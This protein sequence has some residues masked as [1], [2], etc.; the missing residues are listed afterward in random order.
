MSDIIS[1]FLALNF[2]H[3][4]FSIHSA[5]YPYLVMSVASWVGAI[6]SKLCEINCWLVWCK[7]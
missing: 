4:T 7:K 5:K 1:M 3:L 2:C 6:T